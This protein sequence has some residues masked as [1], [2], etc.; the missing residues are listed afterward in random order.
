MRR[1]YYRREI[2]RAE[3]SDVNT[4]AGGALGKFVWISLLICLTGFGLWWLRFQRYVDAIL[5][6]STRGVEKPR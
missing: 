1:Q 2:A 6:A 5:R 4:L 3:A